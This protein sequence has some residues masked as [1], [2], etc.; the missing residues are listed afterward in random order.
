MNSAGRGNGWGLAIL[1]A[2]LAAGMAAST[3]TAARSFERVRSADRTIRVK[4]ASE[5]RIVS[6]WA[7][8]EARFT[9]RAPALTAAYEKI[10]ADLDAVLAYLERSGVPREGVAISSV[11]TSI[12]YVMTE[13]GAVTNRIEGFVLEQTVQVSSGDIPLVTRLARDST[14]LIK[15]GIE[16]ASLPP[17]YYYTK[18]NDLKV[19]ML[20]EATKDAK[21]RAEQLAQNSGCEVGAL[22]SASQG[23]FQITQEYSTA[24]SDYG[25]YDTGSVVKCVKALVTAEFSI[26]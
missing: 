1:G 26:R 15:D 13:K 7:V 19:A 23:V 14:G 5:R 24:V 16:F 3:F 6:D 18:L 8:W 2:M 20:G 17:N 25:V 10:R 4:G 11:S 9:A 12:R 22:R 21:T